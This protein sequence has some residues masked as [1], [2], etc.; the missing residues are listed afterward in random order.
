MRLSYRFTF[1]SS[2]YVWIKKVNVTA[3]NSLTILKTPIRPNTSIE[4]RGRF[5]SAALLITPLCVSALL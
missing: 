1:A 3:L 4:Q 2:R 5:F